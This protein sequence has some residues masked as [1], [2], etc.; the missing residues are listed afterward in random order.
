MGNISRYERSSKK[1][2]RSQ[3]IASRAHGIAPFM[4]LKSERM[5]IR[6]FES[7]ANS[8]KCCDGHSGYTNIDVSSYD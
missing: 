2:A 8:V 3:G 6:K 5:C 4:V 1:E 7:A